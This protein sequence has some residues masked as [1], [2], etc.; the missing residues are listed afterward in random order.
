MEGPGGEGGA[1]LKPD[2]P[3]GG[4]SGRQGA[5]PWRIGLCRNLQ[6]SLGRRAGHRGQRPSCL[7]NTHFHFSPN[8]QTQGQAGGDPTVSRGGPARER[9]RSPALLVKD[10]QSNEGPPSL[11]GPMAQA[12]RELGWART[13]GPGGAHERPWQRWGHS[14]PAEPLPPSSDDLQPTPL[15][16][17]LFCPMLYP[18]CQPL[19]G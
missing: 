15:A 10:Q 12:V 4:V 5:R 6:G 9:A 16:G 17:E 8:A 18:L 3:P 13:C 14:H 1:P 2:S 19:L 11:P 7:S